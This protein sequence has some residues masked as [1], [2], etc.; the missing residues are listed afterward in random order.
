ME[1]FRFS[2]LISLMKRWRPLFFLS[3]DFALFGEKSS[4]E[5]NSI[6]YPPFRGKV[7]A[8]L[9]EKNET[10]HLR[11]LTTN[12]EPRPPWTTRRRWGLHTLAEML[13]YWSRTGRLFSSWK[14]LCL[15]IQVFCMQSE[16][17]RLTKIQYQKGI[18][19]KR[20]CPDLAGQ[21]EME[22]NL[23]EK[24]ISPLFNLNI[25]WIWKSF[26]NVF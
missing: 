1:Q 20:H 24:H 18:S 17:K 8:R 21:V 2:V 9:G 25:I 6:Q 11:Q 10:L 13:I 3:N 14:T 7:E 15:Q 4:S 22:Y 5:E 12:F 26:G 16:K 19:P 23:V